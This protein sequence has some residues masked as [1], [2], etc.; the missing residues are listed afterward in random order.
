MAIT[1]HG[2]VNLILRRAKTTNSEMT[3]CVQVLQH[4]EGLAGD[5]GDKQFILLDF[6]ASGIFINMSAAIVVKGNIGRHF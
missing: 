6:F 4:P 5:I 3:E 2:V 1:F